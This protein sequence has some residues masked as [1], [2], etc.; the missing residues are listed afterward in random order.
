MKRKLSVWTCIFVIIFLCG[1]CFL[2]FYDVY[3]TCCSEEIPCNDS[4]TEAIKEGDIYTQEITCEYD[5]LKMI[6]ISLATYARQNNSELYLS[7][8]LGE[9][10]IQTW[11]VNCIRLADNS[12]YSLLLDHPVKNSKGKVFTI[13]LESN[14]DEKNMIAVYKN[15]TGNYTGLSCNGKLLEGQSFCYLLEYEN[16]IADQAVI[17]YLVRFIAVVSG[18]VIFW[19]V[20]QKMTG[21]DEKIFLAVW[22]SLSLLYSCSITLFN[23]PD[24]YSHFYRA[25][26]ISCGDF[27]A[28]V[29]E[30]QNSGGA[31]LPLDADLTLL[32]QNWVSFEDNKNMELTPESL[33]LK[34]FPNTAIYAPISYLPQAAGIYLARHVTDRIAVI[35]YA[36]RFFNW[37]CTTFILMLAIKIIPYGK[38]ILMLTA[39]IPMNIHEAISLSPDGMIVALSALMIAV[40]LHFIYIQKAPLKRYQI[41]ALYLMALMISLYKITYFPFCL[42]YLLIPK[43]R[44]RQGLKGKAMHMAGLW[45]CAC[46]VSFA[47]LQVANQYP[48]LYPVTTGDDRTL[49]LSYILHHP[50]KYYCVFCRTYLQ[51]AWAL[52]SMMFGNSLGWLNISGIEILIIAYCFAYM[53]SIHAGMEGMT[54]EVFWQKALFGIITILV[55][56]LITTSLYVQVTRPYHPVVTALQGRYY[57]PLLLPVYFVLTKDRSGQPEGMFDLKYQTLVL[58]VNIC[59]CISILFACI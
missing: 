4:M 17:R 14:A 36:G 54:K 53:I 27:I 44:F 7:L 5:G 59:A 50:V 46:V 47:W 19:F 34:L 35:A 58:T 57:L 43:E 15:T 28:D 55:T 40:T 21:N 22:C 29:Y 12:Y 10:M 39:F 49:Q 3:T 8:L 11:N 18:T 24:E 20:L 9:E 33:S 13:R 32:N 56:G 1:S 42:I 23:I 37:L 31:M 6:K 48:S 30:E 26:E 2:T 25:F 16:R 51:Q 41:F 38:R 52:L 45:V